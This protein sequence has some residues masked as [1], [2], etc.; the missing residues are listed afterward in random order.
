MQDGVDAYCV[1]ADKQKLMQETLNLAA[2][3]PLELAKPT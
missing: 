3:L 1:G 2:L